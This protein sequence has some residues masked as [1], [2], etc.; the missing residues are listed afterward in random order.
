MNREF[1]H[2]E[3]FDKLWEELG[4]TDED[5]RILQ[6]MLL[7]NPKAGPQIQSTGGLRKIRV[8]IGGQGKRSSGRVIYVDFLQYE[9]IYLLYVYRKKETENITPT[10]KKEF[11]IVINQIENELK[12]GNRA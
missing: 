1:V 5:L 2:A 10:D 12:R 3:I 9:K 7:D 8:S 4:L 11:K 6:K